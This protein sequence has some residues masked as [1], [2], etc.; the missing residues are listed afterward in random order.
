MYFPI[1]PTLRNVGYKHFQIFVPQVNIGLEEGTGCE[2]KE[3]AF[4]THGG[5]SFQGGL[6]E[7]P[8]RWASG[9]CLWWH[10]VPGQ[11][12]PGQTLPAPSFRGG[13]G[14]LK[15]GAPDRPGQFLRVS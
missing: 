13:Q 12:G 9:H 8:S 11:P 1:Y 10:G 2:N 14:H 7:T 6:H 15:T 4:V 3:T 5:K